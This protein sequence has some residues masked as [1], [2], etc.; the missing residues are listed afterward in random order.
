VNYPVLV[1]GLLEMG[2]KDDDIRNMMGL[3][4]VRVIRENERIARRGPA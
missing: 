3:N 4:L 2:Y 1:K